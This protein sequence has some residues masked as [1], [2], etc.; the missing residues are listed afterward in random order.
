VTFIISL[1][2]FICR[3]L[4]VEEFSNYPDQLKGDNCSNCERIV[5]VLGAIALFYDVFFFFLLFV[6][7]LIST[8]NHDFHAGV[9]LIENYRYPI[10]PFASC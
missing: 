3:K 7:I 1:C 4:L 2:H 9:G 6:A 5:A 10:W 8:E